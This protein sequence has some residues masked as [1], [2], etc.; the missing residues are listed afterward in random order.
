MAAPAK[1]GPRAHSGFQRRVTPRILVVD[2]DPLMLSFVVRAL[3]SESYEVVEARDAETALQLLQ[4]RGADFSLL[5]SDVGLPGLSGPELL[6]RA[7]FLEP[8]LPALLMS[9]SSKDWLVRQGLLGPDQ[10]LLS[11]PFSLGTLLANVERVLE[12]A[13]HTLQAP[14]LAT[15]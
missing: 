14:R 11:K 7:A 13:T 2:D 8:T 10:E 12:A 3:V 1:L 9:A 4:A 5:L 6:E 15:R